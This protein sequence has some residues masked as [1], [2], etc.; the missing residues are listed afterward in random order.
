MPLLG[1]NLGSY[2]G[3]TDVGPYTILFVMFGYSGNCPGRFPI[4]RFSKNLHDYLPMRKKPIDFRVNMVALLT[5]TFLCSTS[6]EPETVADPLLQSI[7]HES[8]SS[9]PVYLTII[10]TNYRN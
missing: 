4:C 1:Q 7:T 6:A 9:V 5:S 10:N 2:G 8:L 3:D